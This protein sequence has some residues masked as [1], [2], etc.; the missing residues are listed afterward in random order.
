MKNTLG[1][2]E[3][4]SVAYG[5]VAA[6]KMLKNG[7]VELIQSAVLC[8]GKYIAMV[9]GDLAAV[10]KAVETGFAE[11]PAFAI[12]SFVLPNIHPSVLSA[13]TGSVEEEIRDSFGI[14]ETEDVSSAVVAA[15]TAAKAANISLIEIR[16]ARGMGGKAYVFLCGEL[17]SVEDAMKF[18]RERVG[19]DGMLLATAVI[20]SP[21]PDLK[22]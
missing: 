19:G 14:I 4:R 11:K 10:Q 13:L 12:S 20:A 17:N 3:Y 6:D 18:V 9:S 21:H 15:D 8:P 22:F 5:M 2:I 16:L 7:S 1:L